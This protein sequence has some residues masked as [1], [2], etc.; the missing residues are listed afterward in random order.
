MWMKESSVQTFVF[1]SA[2]NALNRVTEN[3]FDFEA[4]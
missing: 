3:I 2:G 4:E 1:C